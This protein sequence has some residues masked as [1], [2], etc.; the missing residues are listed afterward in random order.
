M[1]LG[2][3]RNPPRRRRISLKKYL[4]LACFFSAATLWLRWSASAPKH[5]PFTLPARSNW[6]NNSISSAEHSDHP[7]DLLI[8][9]GKQ[10]FDDLLSK[11][12][13]N[14]SAAAA[15]YRTRRGRHPPPGFEAWFEFAQGHD[16]VMVEDF[17]D[18]IYHDLNPFWGLPAKQIRRDA[19]EL[20]M[21]IFI[22]DGKAHAYS[23]WFW[24]QIWLN[25][26]QTVE[27][28][29]P[30]MDLP[31]NAMDEPRLVVPWEDI[32]NYME[33]ELAS[34]RTPPPE[35]VVSEYTG[36]ADVYVEKASARYVKW[37]K[38]Q[39]YYKLARRGCHPKS[40]AR[41]DN[42]KKN[43]SKK[44]NISIRQ[45]E[46][47]LYRGFVSNYTLSTLICHQSDLQGIHGALIKPLTV[48]TTKR[49][50]PIFSGSKLSI[51][52]EIL[53][54]APMYWNSEDRFSGSSNIS[55]PWN[56]KG[57]TLIWR[58]VATGGLNNAHNWKG[59]HRHRLV[60]MLNGT[61]ARLADTGQETPI[62]WQLPTDDTYDIKAAQSHHLGEWLD[63]FSDGGF[64]DLM[65]ERPEPDGGCPYTGSQYRLVQ[66]RPMAEQF[67]YKYLPDIDGNSFSGRYRGF[68]LSSSLPI[69]ATLYREW[70]DSRLVAWKHFVPMDNRFQDFY[71]IMQYFLGYPGPNGNPDYDGS[72]LVRGHD[73]EAEEIAKEGAEWAGRVLRRE[74]MQIYVFRLLLEYARV[75]DD[76][77]ESLGW[78][79]DLL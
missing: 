40:N 46:P 17:W 74:D 68:L 66:G 45:A 39:P 58:G 70:H 2:Y 48:K 49:L 59:F 51:N 60:S 22:R 43:F 52:N 54:P 12:T 30:D 29:L 21:Q 72:D 79:G 73:G 9:A 1:F 55:T 14:L 8:R 5:H 3:V 33:M 18:Q 75:I 26:T 62:N 64:I 67:A 41:K 50:L 78:V 77:R 4:F 38:T 32:D 44:P 35:D 11:R 47:H 57:N 28:Y 71:G 31:L 24:T 69:K 27:Q 15:A 20:G 23:D 65:C 6:L 37:E 34:R 25:L 61:K 42:V 19:K 13:T 36:L 56:E 7:I 10:E 76:K 53:L 16:T 63:S